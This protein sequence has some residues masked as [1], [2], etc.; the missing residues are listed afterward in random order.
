MRHEARRSLPPSPQARRAD[1]SEQDAREGQR[2]WFGNNG[3][4]INL[5]VVDAYPRTVI[6]GAVD[7]VESEVQPK[8]ASRVSRNIDP[9][10]VISAIDRDRYQAAV[11]RRGGCEAVAKNLDLVE[12]R[13]AEC[14][15]EQ[16]SIEIVAVV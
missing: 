3:T 6:R 16:Q 9:N 2:R 4:C 7:R 11:N 15:V 1:G 14:P 12:E 13:H 10:S 5:D 8:W